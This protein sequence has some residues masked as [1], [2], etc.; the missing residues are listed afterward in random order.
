MDHQVSPEPEN[1]HSE[2]EEE[3]AEESSDLDNGPKAD[4]AKPGC[5]PAK[6]FTFSIVNSYGTANIS[7]LPCDG[8]ILKLNRK[9]P[10]PRASD[11]AAFR[12]L[13]QPLPSSP[14]STFHGG[15]RLGHGA[16]EAVL[17]R[18]GSGGQG[19][20]GVL[21]QPRDGRCKQPVMFVL[22]ACVA[23]AYE[24]HESMLQPQK[25]KATVALKE[26]IELFT[27]METLGEHD[28]W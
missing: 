25:K 21:T 14:R 15:H 22:C 1:G 24:K 20:F 9:R 5:A 11:G 8:N 23:Q 12:S 19:V 10:H 2:E 16:E 3:E 28:P 6:L 26:C 18:A 13:L 7:P 27:T 4:T 17:R